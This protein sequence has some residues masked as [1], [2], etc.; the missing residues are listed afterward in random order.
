MRPL[1]L[2]LLLWA[3]GL[4]P[5]AAAADHADSNGYFNADSHR[6]FA[7]KYRDYVIRSFNIDKPYARFVQEQLAGDELAG[8]GPDGD[9]TPA[10]AELLTATHFL[11][12]A[13]DGS[14]E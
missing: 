8:Y 4:W 12:N 2:L 3:V 1:L 11:R 5:G 7:W 14:G 9:V 6:P 10:T 13:P